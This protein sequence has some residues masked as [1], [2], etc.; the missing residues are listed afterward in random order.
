[1]MLYVAHLIKEELQR[2]HASGITR[3]AAIL[4]PFF[5]WLQSQ[6]RVQA[7]TMVLG[8]VLGEGSTGI[9]HAGEVDDQP[10]AIKLAA[11]D[12]D[13]K[14]RLKTETKLLQ[15]PLKPLQGQVVP[16]VLAAGR[17][18]G[19]LT[20]FIAMELLGAP[21][22]VLELSAHDEAQILHSL[23]KIHAKGVLHGDISPGNLL[24]PRAGSN[25][26]VRFV[27]FSHGQI[28]HDKKHNKQNSRHAGAFSSSCVHPQNFCHPG[29]CRR[30][31]GMAS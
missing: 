18:N 9:V 21:V 11:E 14:E 4:A 27:D 20:P 22:E 7:G 24:A 16:T 28:S 3:K 25:A 17:T 19:G 13:A 31:S 29:G 1:M 23:Q 2:R 6:D 26:G 10:A 8:A 5:G 15:G 12:S 30:M